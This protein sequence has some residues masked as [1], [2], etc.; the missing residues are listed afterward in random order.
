[1]LLILF[2]GLIAKLTSVSGDCNVGISEVKH[3]L[4]KITVLILSFF[5]FFV[6][7]TFYFHLQ[8]HYILY[9][10]LY[11]IFSMHLCRQANGFKYMLEHIIQPDR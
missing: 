9:A 7:R 11:G 10:V 1:M 8:E 2:L 5:V 6:F 4:L 3:A